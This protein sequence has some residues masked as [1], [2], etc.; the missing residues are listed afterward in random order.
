MNKLDIRNNEVTEPDSII[1]ADDEE[2]KFDENT[3]NDDP[4]I[5]FIDHNYEAGRVYLK[6]VPMLIKALKKAL[7]IWGDE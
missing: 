2:I 1:F 5:V 4:V 7:E 3:G 6:D